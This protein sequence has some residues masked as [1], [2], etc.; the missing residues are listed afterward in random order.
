LQ[1]ATPGGR[2]RRIHRDDTQEAT[3]S[4]TDLHTAIEAG[5][6]TRVA[7]LVAATPSLAAARDAN[8]VSPVMKALYHRHPELLPALTAAAPPLDVF[9]AAASGDE[10]RLAALLAAD[11]ALARARSADGGTA[12]HFAA[13]FARPECARRLIEAG[14]D[15]HAV[16]PAFGN[17]TP[18]HSAIAACSDAIVA[19][20]LEAGADPNA[21]QAAGYTPLHGAAFHA[22]TDTA[23]LLLAHGADPTATN[24]AGDDAATL[25]E[26]AGNAAFAARLRAER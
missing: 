15:V 22:L 1:A 10:T 19:M 23:E 13:F 3:V 24:D 16:A 18:L 5:D 6:A 26:K 2:I 9:E 8:G 4:V 12:L 21:R 7:T 25:A 20:L 14:A 17:V 11:P